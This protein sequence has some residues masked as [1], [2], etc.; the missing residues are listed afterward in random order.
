MSQNYV[1]V[2]QL[3]QMILQ[4]RNIRFASVALLLL[5]P[6]V[7]ILEQKFLTPLLAIIL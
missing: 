2:L 6:K 3:S 7:I 1:N 5:H 4:P